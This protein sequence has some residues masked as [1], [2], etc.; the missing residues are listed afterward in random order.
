MQSLWS[1]IYRNT[2]T[3]VLAGGRGER[4]YPL[5]Q[6]RSKP[7]VPLGGKYR[8]VDFTLS[9]CLNS[10]L[11]RIYLLTQYKS[12]SLDE[13]I[14]KG[15]NIFSSELGEFI[16]AVPPQQRYRDRWY[17]GTADAIFQNLNLFDNHKPK[18]VVI[19]SGDH[20]YKMDYSKMMAA[21]IEKAADI[22]ISTIPVRLED[23]KRFGVC[24]V[25][26]DQRI[27][28]FQEKIENPMEIPDRPGW[29]L[30]SMGVYIFNTEVLAREVSQDAKRNS[31]HDFG[32]DI[33]PFILD[34]RKVYAFYFENEG[35]DSRKEAYWRDIGTLDSYFEASLDWVSLNPEFNLYDE[36]WPIRTYQGQY[37]PAKTVWRG[38]ER[39]GQI[40]ESIVSGGVIVSG[41]TV[42]RSILS[43]NVRV[44]SYSYA[45]E[46]LLFEKVNVGR[47]CRLRRVIIDK[48]V[49][50]PEG[51]VIGYDHE[52]DKKQFL[53]TDKGVTV[54]P[55]GYVF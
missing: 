35:E 51:T 11:H 50:V 44:N 17:S 24:G 55:K 1:R 25:D 34:K 23:A 49:T 26:K 43:P 32:R 28:A 38:E 42:V 45:E 30:G 39:R 31:T 37:P 15:W 19:L 27:I 41:G 48:Y 4:L 33:I 29:C 12:Q 3:M 47:R 2:L 5:T 20:I 16:Y 53:I 22:T 54:I 52:A 10:G 36:S 13:H 8:I 18:Y 6:P 9:N 40:I 46:C 14:R 7:A 21:H